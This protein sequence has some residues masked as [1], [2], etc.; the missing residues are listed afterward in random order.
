MFDPDAGL[1]NIRWRVQGHPDAMF[2]RRVEEDPVPVTPSIASY[3]RKDNA[4]RV[5]APSTWSHRVGLFA[6]PEVLGFSAAVAIHRSASTSISAGPE[7]L[8]F[9]LAANQTA[10]RPTQRQ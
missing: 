2:Y 7:N 8:I 5:S 9:T 10:N 3:A 4:E 6:P 1:P